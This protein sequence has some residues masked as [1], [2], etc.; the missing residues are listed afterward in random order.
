MD[1]RARIA[2][3]A[4]TLAASPGS[5]GGVEVG[6][7]DDAAVLASPGRRMVWTIDEQVDGTHFE[8]SFASWPDIGW[9]SFMAAASDV[10]AMGAEPWCALCALVLPDDV[11]DDALGAIARGQRDAAAAIRA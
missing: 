3:L 8:R 6:I 1:E 7:G 9:R 2:L 5:A 4:R 10:A 11:D